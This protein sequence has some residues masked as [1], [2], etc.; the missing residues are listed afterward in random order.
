MLL[1]LKS[2]SLWQYSTKSRHVWKQTA[3][4]FRLLTDWTSLR[5]IFL[6]FVDFGPF[7]VPFWSSSFTFLKNCEIIFAAFCFC[8]HRLSKDVSYFQNCIS[9]WRYYFCPNIFVNRGVISVSHFQ[10]KSSFSTSK[11]THC[12]I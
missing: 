8:L 2:E 5:I 6:F 1:P 10:I 12:V 7:S 4:S 9:N 3:V 11:N